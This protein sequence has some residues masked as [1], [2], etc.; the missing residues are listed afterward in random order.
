M[1]VV[2]SRHQS[3]ETAKL[4]IGLTEKPC[5]MNLLKSRLNQNY[6]KLA[7]CISF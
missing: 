2:V 4:S 7:I 3:A 6:K 5:H 1:Y